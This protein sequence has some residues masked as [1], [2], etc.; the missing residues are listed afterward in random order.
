MIYSSVRLFHA[1]DINKNKNMIIDDLEQY[2]A[3]RSFWYTITGEFNFVKPSINMELTIPIDTAYGT[4]RNNVQSSYDVLA[5]TKNHAPNYASI[6]RKAD[7]SPAQAYRH[8]Y[9]FIDKIEWKSDKAIKLYMTMDVL[10]TFSIDT[11]FTFSTN[12]LVKRIHKDRFI[13]SPNNSAKM[14]RR[15]DE[16][17]EGLNP[18]LYN[19][20]EKVLNRGDAYNHK[21]YAIYRTA[22]APQGTDY[23][24]NNPVQ[25]TITRDNPFLIKY[26]WVDITTT[27]MNTLNVSFMRIATAGNGSGDIYFQVMRDKKVYKIS[28]LAGLRE[29]IYYLEL[30]PAVNPDMVQ[31]EYKVACYKETGGGTGTWVYKT[32]KSGTSEIAIIGAKNIYYC[33]NSAEPVGSLSVDP[34]PLYYGVDSYVVAGFEGLDRTDSKLV[35]VIELPYAPFTY[36]IDSSKALVFPDNVGMAF[37]ESELVL[38][39]EEAFKGEELSI[40]LSELTTEYTKPN[41]TNI[42]DAYDISNES[43]LFNSEFYSLKEVYDSF[44]CTIPFENINN[45]SISGTPILKFICANT[46]T[47]KMLFKVLNTPYKRDTEDFKGIIPVSR[48]NE[49][50]IYTSQYL[51]YLR[52]GY[53]YDLKAKQRQEASSGVGM[54]LT[55]LGSIAGMALGVA[56]GNPAIAIGSIVSGTTAIASSVVSNVNSIVSAEESLQAKLSNLKAQAISVSS[57]DDVSLLDYYADDN[58]AKEVI[59]KVSDNVRNALGYMFHTIGYKVDIHSTDLSSLTKT[60]KWFNFI[61]AD[62]DIASTSITLP[63]EFTEAYKAKLAEGVFRYHKNEINGARTWNFAMTY[64]NWEVSM[65]VNS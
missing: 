43:K 32:I 19:M 57:I 44:S 13:E 62:I 24:D 4:T 61:Q 28:G 45:T 59:Y 50:S 35:K 25:C 36:T 17:P 1:I 12:T 48:N 26:S 42:Q 6:S 64:E 30:T 14:I 53:N 40:D 34:T 7:V 9:Y 41:S 33:S 16:T 23:T 18:I 27:L 58:K 3:V 20:N 56:S 47:S 55:A 10:N 63:M 52:T 37:D 51:N 11:D 60:R 15:V 21:W 5:F 29:K 2:L 39:A 54:G 65:Y 49:V 38:Y 46:I 8:L 31:Y 22:N